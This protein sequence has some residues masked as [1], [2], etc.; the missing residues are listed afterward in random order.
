MEM[1]PTSLALP[2]AANLCED[3]IDDI[4]EPSLHIDM[5]KKKKSKKGKVKEKDVR[6]SVRR[7]SRIKKINNLLI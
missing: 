5:H 1:D 4:E 3:L 6:V 2:R 7:S